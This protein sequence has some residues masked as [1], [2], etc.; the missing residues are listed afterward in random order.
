MRLC[1]GIEL[2]EDEISIFGG[3]QTPRN[4]GKIALKLGGVPSTEETDLQKREAKV[5]SSYHEEQI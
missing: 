3:I 4:V 5:A 1:L 2:S